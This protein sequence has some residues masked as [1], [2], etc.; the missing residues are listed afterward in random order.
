MKVMTIVTR[1]MVAAAL[2]GAL[3]GSVW[4]QTTP[5]APA[6]TA[7]KPKLICRSTDEIGS[8]LRKTRRCLTA[9]QWRQQSRDAQD[10]VDKRMRGVRVESG[11]V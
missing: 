9:E 4:A 5:V 7:E 1:C 2:S 8:R 10:D 3:G 11:G 6:T